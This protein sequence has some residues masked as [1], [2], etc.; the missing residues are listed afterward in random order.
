MAC[1][2]DCFVC[3]L[4]LY[5]H[6]STWKGGRIRAATADAYREV[7]S[8]EHNYKSKVDRVGTK[9]RGLSLVRLE[10]IMKAR[11]FLYYLARLMGDVQAISSGSP[12]KMAKR[13]FNKI[14]GRKII[15]KAWWR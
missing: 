5:Y 15:S 1:N 14:V 4:L 6:V 7:G 8:G 13:G 2:V 3:N 10:A 11:G 9:R 12:K